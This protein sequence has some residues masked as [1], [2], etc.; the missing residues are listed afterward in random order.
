M[1]F[2]NNNEVLE[3]NDIL[4]TAS[5][6]STR[7]RWV[8]APVHKLTALLQKHKGAINGK[9]LL[10]FMHSIAQVSREKV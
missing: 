5:N 6:V 7:M 1:C 8:A 2:L 10:T 3:S 9:L 4:I